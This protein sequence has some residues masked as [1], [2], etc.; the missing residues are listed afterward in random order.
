MVSKWT[1]NICADESNSGWIFIV[2]LIWCLQYAGTSTPDKVKKRIIDMLC[3]WRVAFPNETKI[4]DA[5]TALK[6]QGGL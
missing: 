4:N 6:K 2:S 5:Y 1:V 3:S